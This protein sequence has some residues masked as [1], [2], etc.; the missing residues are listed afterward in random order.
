MLKSLQYIAKKL[1]DA[2]KCRAENDFEGTFHCHEK[3]YRVISVLENGLRNLADVPDEAT[4]AGTQFLVGFYQNLRNNLRGLSARPEWEET[5]TQLADAVKGLHSH[6][7][8]HA[9]AVSETPAQAPVEGVNL[10]N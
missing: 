6:M 4:R 10:M 2:K 5:Y 8:K 7:F 3:M 1:E 9:D